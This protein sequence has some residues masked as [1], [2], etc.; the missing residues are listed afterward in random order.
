MLVEGGKFDS[1]EEGEGAIYTHAH[2][3]GLQNYAVLATK[4]NSFKSVRLQ[5]AKPKVHM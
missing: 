4:T 1:A 5:N 2:D 3:K